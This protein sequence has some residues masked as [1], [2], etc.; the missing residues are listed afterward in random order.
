MKSF[1]QYIRESIIDIPRKDYSKTIFDKFNTNDPVLKPSIKGMI[2]TQLKS[3]SN[4]A[5]IVKYRLIGSILTKQYRKDADLDVNVFFNV[6][7]GQKEQALT[8]L[9]AVVKKVNGKN[10][11]GTK[12]P[13]NYF[14]IVDKETYEKANEMADNVYDIASAKFEKR[15]PEQ[16][17]DIDI[18]LKDFR[19]RVEK[20]DILKGELSRDIVDYEELKELDKDDIENLS[21]R[22]KEKL[23][24]LEKD[25]KVLINIGKDVWSDRQGAFTKDMSPEQIRKYGVRNRLP[26][27][28]VY[29]MLEKYYYIQLMHDLEDIL[30]DDK[31]LSDK[32]AK[33]LKI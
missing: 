30:G 5:P 14:V 13:V 6:P 3:F 9:R 19:K 21:G 32:E 25:M 31:K 4:I 12:H 18:Y 20:I 27:N 15:S 33:K 1:K 8:K 7:T 10:V 23:A 28:V 16:A 17:P 11:P 26:K 29:K 22:V 24:E 2:E